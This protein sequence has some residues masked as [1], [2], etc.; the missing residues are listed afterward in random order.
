MINLKEIKCIWMESGYIDYKICDRNFDCENCPFD[1]AIHDKGNNLVREL[2]NQKPINYKPSL[3]DDYLISNNHVWLKKDRDESYLLGL[4]YFSKDL[5][6]QVS[7]FQFPAVGSRLFKNKPLLWTIGS[8][9]VVS[10]NSPISGVIIEVNEKL[11]YN[12]ALFVSADLYQLF[13]V[14][15]KIETVDY[16]PGCF[17]NKHQ[18]DDFIHE[19][20]ITAVEYIHSTFKDM[21]V[22]KTMYDGGEIFDEIQN[23]TSR[24]DYLKLLKMFFNKKS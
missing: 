3:P 23:M 10:I 12:P 18:Y 22:G 7:S 1:Q 16:N 17:M 6:K 5:I 24:E 2:K 4:D 14:R 20:L 9:G 13:F 8:W 11:R 15:A 19:E 21:S